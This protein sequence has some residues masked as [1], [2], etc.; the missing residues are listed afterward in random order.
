MICFA[1]RSTQDNRDRFTF[2]RAQDQG[3]E[4]HA[5]C[6]VCRHDFVGRQGRF[7][8]Y[9][10]YLF[11]PDVYDRLTVAIKRPVAH[12]ISD[13]AHSAVGTGFNQR[14]SN[15]RQLLPLLS[16]SVHPD[17]DN[18]IVKIVGVVVQ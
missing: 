18:V 11:E 10:P 13:C 6:A 2:F 8:G 9:L 14:F 1:I 16:I 4:V 5:Y 7:R 15:I 17:V 12:M 3:A